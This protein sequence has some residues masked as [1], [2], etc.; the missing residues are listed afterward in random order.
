MRIINL[1]QNT[2]AWL[3][4][5][6]GKFSASQAPSV[7]AESKYFPK[8]PYELYLVETGQRAVQYTQAM[9]DGHAYESRAL[10]LTNLF[11]DTNYKPVCGE[12]DINPKFAASLDGYDALAKTSVV[13]IKT[14]TQ[15]S[16]IWENGIDIYRWQLVHQCLVADCNKALL[17]AYCKDS[18]TIKP[19]VF[20]CSDKDKSRLQKAWDA[21]ALATDNFMPPALTDKDYIESDD[22]DLADLLHTRRQAKEAIS[23]IEARIRE[24][25]EKIYAKCTSPTKSAGFSIYPVTRSGNVN[26]KKIP[27]LEG[28]DLDKYRGKPIRYWAIKG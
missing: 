1:E 22:N 7:M 9:K 12:S 26:Y 2:N 18:D 10:E 3:A 11:F 8:T 15:G 17:I 13:E 21:Y 20:E 25:E 23:D 5:R 4:W 16:S 27:Q 14:T 6:F 19:M 24:L 28:V